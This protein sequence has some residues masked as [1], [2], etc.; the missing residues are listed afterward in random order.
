MD[1]SA[2]RRHGRPGSLRPV[3]QVAGNSETPE[4]CSRANETG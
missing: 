1:G 3:R 4:T 2:R